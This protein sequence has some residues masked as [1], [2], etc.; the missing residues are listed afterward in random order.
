MFQSCKYSPYSGCR[1]SSSILAFLAMFLANSS[2]ISPSWNE[3]NFPPFCTQY[4]NNGTSSPGILGLTVQFSSNYAAQLTSF[5]AC[6]KNLPNLFKSTWLWWIMQEVAWPS[7]QRV[8][9]AIR[10]SRVR[11]SLWP[12]VGWQNNTIFFTEFIYEE[13]FNSQW[14]KTLLFCPQ[15]YMVATISS[16]AA[17]TR[18]FGCTQNFCPLIIF[19]FS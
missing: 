14:N 10:R 17:H 5:L 12:L 1:P 13:Y 2:P 15:T 8:G 6:R 16:T 7:G 9:L 19:N 3:W 18:I 11:V 4:Q